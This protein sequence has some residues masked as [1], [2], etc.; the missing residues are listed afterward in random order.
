MRND[1]FEKEPTRE[2]LLMMEQEEA[3]TSEAGQKDAE[4]SNDEYVVDSVRMYLRDISRH[5]LLSAAEEIELGRIIAEGGEG[6]QAAKDKLVTSNLRLVVSIAKKSQGRGVD[7]EDLIMMGNEGLIK[8]VE[9]YDYTLGYKFSTYAT[10][11]IRQAIS[12]GLANERTAIRIPVHMNETM[13]KVAFAQKVF[14]QQTGVEA[15]VEDIIRMT[16]LSDE[17]VRIALDSAYTMVST[18]SAIGED[19]DTTFGEM[20]EDEHA[21][22]PE[23]AAIKSELKVAV[24]KLLAK[25][26]PKEARVL[27]LRMG[28]ETGSPMTL[29]EIAD[30]AD[31]KVSRERVRQIQNKAFMKIQ[32]LPAARELAAQY[33]VS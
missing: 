27:R 6:A 30:L 14:K 25:L 23:E 16:G 8:S 3:Q 18:D 21:V 2:E 1:A 22:N 28:M 9:K 17:V 5:P 33:L 24:E 32:R 19:K 31:F 12:R 10:W 11:W 7:L 20:Q 13:Q 29:E 26:T 4:E 15:G